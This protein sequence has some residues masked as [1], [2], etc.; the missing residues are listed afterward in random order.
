MSS[1]S[2]IQNVSTEE[3]I[4]LRQQIA[5]MKF[6]FPTVEKNNAYN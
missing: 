4:I 6:F 3:S 5:N 1:V 2:F